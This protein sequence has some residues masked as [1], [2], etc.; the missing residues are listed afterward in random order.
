MPHL[1]S[2]YAEDLLRQGCDIDLETHADAPETHADGRRMQDVSEDKTG[3]A[4]L[5][6]TDP[7]SCSWDSFDGP[8]TAIPSPID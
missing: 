1:C 6:Q 3:M 8:H 7:D 2:E 4:K 5:L